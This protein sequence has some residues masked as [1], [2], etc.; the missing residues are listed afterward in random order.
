MVS[1]RWVRLSAASEA[2]I[3]MHGY[4]GLDLIRDLLQ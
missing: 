4:N 1:E 2:R 3:E